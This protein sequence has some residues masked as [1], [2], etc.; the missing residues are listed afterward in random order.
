MNRQTKA[1][2]TNTGFKPKTFLNAGAIS[3]AFDVFNSKQNRSETQTICDLCRPN[4]QT[5]TSSTA[6]LCPNCT[7]AQNRLESEL[8]AQLIK[9]R[10]IIRLHRCSGCWRCVTPL[11]FSRDWGICKSCVADVQE[12]SKL[13]RSNFIERAVN[14]FRKMLQGV[15]T[16]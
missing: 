7:A 16:L 9:P 11:K 12:K 2:A 6:R 13:A 10:K 5:K 14:N 8:L 15:V 4:L 1:G 3:N